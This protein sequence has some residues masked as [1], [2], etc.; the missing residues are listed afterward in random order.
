[1]IMAGNLT[2]KMALALRKVYD[3]MAE[4]RT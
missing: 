4:P 1:M 3:H 2:N